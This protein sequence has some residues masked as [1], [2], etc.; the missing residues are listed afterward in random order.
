MTGNDVS[1]VIVNWNSGGQLAACLAS[2]A[3][4]GGARLG[5]IIVVDNGSTDGSLEVA[6]TIK[7]VHVV[8]SD[9]NLGFSRACNLGASHVDD[10]YLLFLNPDAAVNPGTLDYVV[11]FM[12]RPENIGVGICGV[13]LIDERGAVARSCAR[14]PTPLA[15]C[16]LSLGLHRVFPRQGVLMDDWAHDRRKD[17]DHVIGAFYF[18]RSDL[19]RALRGF[20]ER[21]FVYLED[22]DFSL[23]LHRLGRRCVY[24]TDVNAFHAG[25]GT[26]NQVKDRRLFYALRSRL[27]FGFKHFDFLG[28]W[29]VMLMTVFVEPL[30]RSAW[31]L[32]RLSFSSFTATWRGYGML[33]RWLPQW[34]LRGTTR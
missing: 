9:E 14:F 17:V 23:R 25:G 11:A 19:F 28:A 12:E 21:F 3:H 29:V 20:D 30:V 33:W 22:L 2:L 24:L 15:F 34:A 13:Q 27:L 10:K 1:V 31:A 26:S 32:G 8:Q 7:A 6:R 16:L 5:R 4:H 18:V